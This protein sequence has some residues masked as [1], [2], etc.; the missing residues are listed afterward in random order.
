MKA[1]YYVVRWE[2][3]VYNMLNNYARGYEVYT[4]KKEAEKKVENLKKI[5]FYDNLKL[6]LFDLKGW[7][8][9]NMISKNP[10]KTEKTNYGYVQNKGFEFH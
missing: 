8:L 9:S 4:N 10:E 6:E 3:A 5:H 2:I 7:E 1:K